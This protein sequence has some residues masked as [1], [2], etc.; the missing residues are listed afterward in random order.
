[1]NHK[2]FDCRPKVVTDAGQ[3]Y[4]L[5]PCTI[6][7][8]R[9]EDMAALADL[10]TCAARRLCTAE[11]TPEQIATMLRFGL[12]VDE[13]V[14]ADRTCHVVEAPCGI[15]AVGAWSYRAAVMGNFHPSYQ[16]DARDVLNPAVEAARFRGFF[17]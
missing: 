15:I 11:L 6:R 17:T 8:A 4:G 2:T 14:V 9:L 5:P 12:G 10:A 7:E 16:G 13:Q 1:M 3:R